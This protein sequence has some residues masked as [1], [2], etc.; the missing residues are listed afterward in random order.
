[1]DHQ[2]ERR[3]AG[4]GLLVEEHGLVLERAATAA[5]LLGHREAE[6]AQLA[7]TAVEGA[8]GVAAG[9]ELL[10]VRQDL[11]G[12]ERPHRPRQVVVL[13]G[14]PRRPVR[15][16]VAAPAGLV[17]SGI[18]ASVPPPQT[19]FREAPLSTCGARC[20]DR[21]VLVSVTVGSYLSAGGEWV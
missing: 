17:L 20:G 1:V 14:A 5:V 8:V 11:A 13:G 12:E 2:A 18:D 4:A 15:R 3:V 19:A 21:Y 10:L 6:Q 16:R 9:D 7:G